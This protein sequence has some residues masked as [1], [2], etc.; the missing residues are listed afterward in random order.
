MT[1]PNQIEQLSIIGK[2]EVGHKRLLHFW[3][4]TIFPT[5]LK[6]ILFSI[7]IIGN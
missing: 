6:F 3:P 4:Q 5:D 7:V 2:K 1:D